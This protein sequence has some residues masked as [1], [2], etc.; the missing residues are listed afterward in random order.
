MKKVWFIYFFFKKHCSIKI[1][2]VRDFCVFKKFQKTD[3]V[4][5]VF[6]LKKVFCFYC[7]NFNDFIV[8]IIFVP[9]FLSS[10]LYITTSNIFFS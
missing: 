7:N 2:D 9:E 5:F 4:F 3:T 6:I 1:F 8:L 10:L